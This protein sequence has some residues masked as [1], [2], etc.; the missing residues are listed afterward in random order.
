MGTRPR[1]A[2]CSE[3]AGTWLCESLRALPGCASFRGIMPTG[4][5][6]HSKTQES[7]TCV[8]SWGQTHLHHLSC[9]YVY[10]TAWASVF[11]PGKWNEVAGQGGKASCNLQGCF[12]VNCHSTLRIKEGIQPAGVPGAHME[13]EPL[14]GPVCTLLSTQASGSNWHQHG[15]RPCC[16]RASLK[17][18][19][20]CH[21]R[22]VPGTGVSTRTRTVGSGLGS[23]SHLPSGRRSRP[24]SL[25]I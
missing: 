22:E 8:P 16:S 21:G 11:G 25:G 19:S 7:V 2:T 18:S 13:Q 5:H 15:I 3:A 4:A 20:R 6:Q 24:E 1:N 14:S 10:Y 12:S 17:G 23:Y 9:V